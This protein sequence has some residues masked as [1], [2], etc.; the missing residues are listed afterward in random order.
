M[1]DVGE[2]GEMKGGEIRTIKRP[3][4]QIRLK[5]K[6]VPRGPAEKIHLRK[7]PSTSEKSRFRT[8]ALR[9]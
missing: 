4:E 3:D 5:E 6:K 1:K 2:R 7:R 8:Q 9:R